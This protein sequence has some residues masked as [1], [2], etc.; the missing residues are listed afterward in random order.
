MLWPCNDLINLDNFAIA[1][2]I[3]CQFVNVGAINN[4]K[5]RNGINIF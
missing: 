4:C 1:I 2:V 3:L 5:H